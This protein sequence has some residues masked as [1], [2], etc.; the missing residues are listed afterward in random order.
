METWS[1]ARIWLFFQYMI[2]NYSI[3]PCLKLYVIKNFIIVFLKYLL[4][5]IVI[6]ETC[7]SQHLLGIKKG[8]RFIVQAL[9]EL[10]LD[11]MEFNYLL[12]VKYRDL[13]LPLWTF[14]ELLFLAG[15]VLCV[16]NTQGTTE[17]RANTMY[18][19]SLMYHDDNRWK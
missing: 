5:N 15:Q 2:Y 13:F 10:F 16:G 6:S 4:W 8:L 18:I 17:I 11:R 19:Q 14:I 7:H 1:I 3:H 9:L 12:A